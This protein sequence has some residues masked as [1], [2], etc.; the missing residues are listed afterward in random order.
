MSHDLMPLLAQH[1]CITL[2]QPGA[3]AA[4]PAA[5]DPVRHATL[6]GYAAMLLDL[7]AELA[8]PDLVCLGHSVSAMIGALAAVQAPDA[9][10][11]WVMLCPLPC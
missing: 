1:R 10:S 8:E 9:F 3:G 7:L 2:N 6:Q 4:N 5:C 11:Q